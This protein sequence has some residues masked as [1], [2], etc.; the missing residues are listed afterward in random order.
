V[1]KDREWYGTTE[2]WNKLL[3]SP[4]KEI[5]L[6]RKHFRTG[7]PLGNENFLL[8]AERITGRELI[9]RKPG[10]KRKGNYD[11]TK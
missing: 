1:V 9:L 8:E 6:L 7:R 11:N 3:S 4:P 2:D 10:R 5:E